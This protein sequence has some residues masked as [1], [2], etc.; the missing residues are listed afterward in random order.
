VIITKSP[1][2]PLPKNGRENIDGKRGYR[3]RKRGIA[4]AYE[5]I[6]Q[7]HNVPGGQAIRQLSHEQTPGDAEAQPEQ[8]NPRLQSLRVMLIQTQEQL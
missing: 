4:A 7:P 5:H 1:R 3:N 2:K 8:Q 6:D